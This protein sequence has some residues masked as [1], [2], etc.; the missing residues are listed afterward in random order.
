MMRTC[1]SLSGVYETMAEIGA[2]RCDEMLMDSLD[3]DVPNPHLLMALG[4][5]IHEAPFR[6]IVERRLDEW[7]DSM[8]WMPYQDWTREYLEKI[9]DEYE[10]S[11]A[12]GGVL[13]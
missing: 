1:P 10:R 7:L 13:E 3:D 4:R 11:P 8:P 12:S 6:S 5:R 9:A 2:P